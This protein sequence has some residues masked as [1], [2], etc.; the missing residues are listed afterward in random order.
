MSI[1]STAPS[2]LKNASKTLNIRKLQTINFGQFAI[3]FQ[4]VRVLY[5]EPHLNGTHF[6]TT[7]PDI[8]EHC[9]KYMICS[10]LSWVFMCFSNFEGISPYKAIFFRKQNFRS[11]EQLSSKHHSRMPINWSFIEFYNA[12]MIFSLSLY[13]GF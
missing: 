6:Q 12:P 3:I 13:Q 7:R 2:M 4:G 10:C 9:R 1:D 5:P 11:R 8:L